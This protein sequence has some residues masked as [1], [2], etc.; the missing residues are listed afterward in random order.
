[1]CK[2]TYYTT[3]SGARA[4]CLGMT[5]LQELR[6]YSIQSLHESLP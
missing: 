5:H 4:A 2:I 6:P 3:I 1:M